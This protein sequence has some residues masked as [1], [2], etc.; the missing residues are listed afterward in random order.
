MEKGAEKGEEG[1]T[2]T[3]ASERLALGV[4]SNRKRE[5]G[6]WANK[7]FWTETRQVWAFR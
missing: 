5:R 2:T 3:D 6:W 4:F 7:G 1:G